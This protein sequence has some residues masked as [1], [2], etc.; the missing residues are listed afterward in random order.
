MLQLNDSMEPE[1]PGA[2]VLHPEEEDG[3][4]VAFTPPEAVRGLGRASSV[5]CCPPLQTL[6]PF[7]VH[8]PT[9]Q[10]KVKDYFVF[11]PG[12][13][14]QAVSDIRTVALPSED[15]E[16][17]SVWLLAEIDHWNNER[18]RLVLITERSLLVCKREGYGIRVQWDK[19]P[20]ASFVNR[21][22]P[23]ST[24]MPYAT[25]TEHPMAHADEKVASL[26][27]LPKLDN[28]RS[29]LVQAV[30]RAHKEHPIP[31]RAN[32]VLILERPL[33]IETYLG[34]MSFINN[35][36]KLGYS[37]TRGRIGF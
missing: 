3:V 23:W 20:R 28:F 9:M 26:C 22:N 6:T 15:G 34:I 16:V 5:A 31:G 18:E 4:E 2:A 10:A 8:N 33:L 21:W 37:M 1:S 11:R 30:K 32:G 13:I 35:E 19:R 29:Q 12:T 27:Q 17:L 7:H 25:F 36:A 14:E 24:E